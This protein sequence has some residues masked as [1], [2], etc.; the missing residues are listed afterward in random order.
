M[1]YC[2][3][4]LYSERIDRFYAGMTEDLEQRIFQH[5]NPFLALYIAISCDVNGTHLNLKNSSKQK[6]NSAFIRNQK[7]YP[8][9]V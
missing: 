1:R 3:Y 9:L 2:V 5:N 7:K 8:E 4:I 6:K